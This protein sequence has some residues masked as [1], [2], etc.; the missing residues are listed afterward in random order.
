MP[1]VIV[2]LHVVHMSSAFLTDLLQI[3]YTTPDN[4]NNIGLT[5]NP[6]NQ[7]RQVEWKQSFSLSLKT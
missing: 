7:L 6:E 1:V 4:P 3:K 2:I 5:F